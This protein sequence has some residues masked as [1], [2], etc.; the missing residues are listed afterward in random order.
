[1]DIFL[2]RLDI[3]DFLFCRVCVIE[4]QVGQPSELLGNPEI[5]ADRLGMTNVQVAIGFRR[6]PRMDSTT[7]PIGP[8]VLFYHFPNKV[9]TDDAFFFGHILRSPS[10]V[11]CIKPFKS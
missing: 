10:Q 4:P 9:G 1:M 8:H 11:A 5:Q 6:E 2:D 7:E 3:L